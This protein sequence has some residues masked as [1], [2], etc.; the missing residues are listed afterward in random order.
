MEKKLM[1][2]R[3]HESLPLLTAKVPQLPSLNLPDNSPEIAK[4]KRLHDI[5]A[6]M[7]QRF[8]E[9]AEQQQSEK[10]L[11]R[12]LSPVKTQRENFQ[13]SKDEE[14]NFKTSFMSNSK[15]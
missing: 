1:S 14:F 9:K 15:P 11:P 7:R 10:I 3:R 8:I 6:K 12:S 13:L 2:G 5:V 4:K